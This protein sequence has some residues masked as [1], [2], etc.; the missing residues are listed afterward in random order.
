M[1]APFSIIWNHRKILWSIVIN[2]MKAKYAGSMLGMI[3]SV[4][5]PILFLSVYFIVYVLIF[6]IRLSTMN[7]FEYVML[8]FCG[9]IPWFGFAESVG[10]GVHAVTANSNL[11]K[12][13]LF[14]IELIP[15][16]VVLGSLV[17]QLIGLI[18]LTV[19]LFIKG[20]AGITIIFIPFLLILQVVFSI[21]LIWILSSLNVFF[22]D[23]GQIISVILILLMMI[24]PIAYTNDMIPADLLGYMKINPLYYMITMYRSMLMYN[25]LPP[26]TDMAIFTVISLV[27]FYLGYY[28]F[29]RLKVVFA[30]YV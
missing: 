16:K 21:G 25:Q 4:L 23:L 12:N 28:I 20:M 5:Y 17:S 18:M 9:L 8:I 26:I 30:D 14:P 27:L 2:D 22:R 6:K 24:S 1:T 11:I 3:W 29:S 7:T 13:T 15:V 10:L 19:L